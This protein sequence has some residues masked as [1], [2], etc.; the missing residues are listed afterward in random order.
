MKEIYRSFDGK[1]GPK[2][3]A[4]Y[5]VYKGKDFYEVENISAW[6]DQPNGRFR[7]KKR[8]KLEGYNRNQ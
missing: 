6:N 2:N 7:V 8:A 1:L 4:G 3:Q 5:I